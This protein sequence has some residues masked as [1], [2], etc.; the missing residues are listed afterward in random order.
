M[1]VT[2][3]SWSNN[4]NKES[5]DKP[6][7]F[8]VCHDTNNWLSAHYSRIYQLYAVTKTKMK[9]EYSNFW[10]PIP[11]E[12]RVHRAKFRI[13]HRISLI[14]ICSI[15]LHSSWND[16]SLEPKRITYNTKHTTNNN[17]NKRP[18]ATA[19]AHSYAALW[20]SVERRALSH[21]LYTF[22]FTWVGITNIL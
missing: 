12:L 1:E 6:V 20:L 2:F 11:V 17:N 7:K 3:C 15:I 19:L 4:K 16:S 10:L 8:P 9:C 18:F 21:F 13:Y 5:Y 14:L 22:L